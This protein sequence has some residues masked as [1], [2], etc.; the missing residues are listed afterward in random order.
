MAQQGN[1]TPTIPNI[2]V[3]APN[4][5][6][7]ATNS[8]SSHFNV[9]SVVNQVATKNDASSSNNQT[10]NG[11][12]ALFASLST[13]QHS[14]LMEMLQSHLQAAET[15]NVTPPM[16]HVAGTCFLTFFSPIH[17]DSILWIIDSGTSSHIC[18]QR[19]LFT[20]L[21][22]A[23]KISVVLPTHSWISVDLIGTIRLSDDF[24]LHDV[25][26]ILE[27][28]YNLIPMS[29]LLKQGYFSIEFS[30]IYCFIQDRS[31]SRM[32]DKAESVNKCEWTLFL[33]TTFACCLW[34]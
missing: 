14:Q 7:A 1:V 8:F 20:D 4:T 24:V 5:T 17:H 15:D 22:P 25:L 2:E 3:V 9:A 16:T 33:I 19:S 31:L 34:I 18:H 27:F 28:N 29:A 30:S 21:R 23:S 26:F 12:P 6:M 32:I 10:Y 13:N 11:Q